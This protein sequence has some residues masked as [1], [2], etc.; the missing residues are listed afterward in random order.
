MYKRSLPKFG[1]LW[2]IFSRYPELG[3]NINTLHHSITLWK[4]LGQYMKRRYTDRGKVAGKVEHQAA[5]G[6]VAL[7]ESV[8]VHPTERWSRE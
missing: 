2:W 6:K 3:R 1:S 4:L 7:L 8:V 5:V